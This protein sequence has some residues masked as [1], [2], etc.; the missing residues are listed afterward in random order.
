MV[1]VSPTLVE[2]MIHYI[3]LAA[4][5]LS[6]WDCK[7]EGEK[8]RLIYAEETIIYSLTMLFVQRMMYLRVPTSACTEMRRVQ[9]M[10][11]K[12]NEKRKHE[13]SGK[14]KVYVSTNLES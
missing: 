8:E 7:S 1:G 10:R 12:E 4:D 2:T 14:Y 11:Q 9:M 6:E 13:L 3:Q 5:L